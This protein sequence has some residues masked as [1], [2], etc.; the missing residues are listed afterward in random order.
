M[1]KMA[2]FGGL[3]PVYGGG[4]ATY[5]EGLPTFDG[6]IIALA[7]GVA[8]AALGSTLD[9]YGRDASFEGSESYLSFTLGGA[10]AINEMY[11]FCLGLRYITG[12][13]NIAGSIKN[14]TATAANGADIV[15]VSQAV[16]DNEITDIE[17][18]LQQKGSGIGII[19]GFDVKPN[20]QFNIGFKY[21]YYTEMKY[22]NETDKAIAPTPIAPALAAYKDGEESK[23]TIPMMF[24]IGASYMPTELF[25]AELGIAYY[26]NSTVDWDNTPEGVTSTY[27]QS[28]YF[29][30]GYEIGISGEYAIVPDKF[31]ASLGYLYTFN[32]GKEEAQSDLDF[33]QPSNGLSL[34]GI[35]SAT[36]TLDITLGYMLI[37]YGEKENEAETQTYNNTTH[38]IGFG[39]S[40]YKE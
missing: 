2:F 15:A 29:D 5:D 37:K 14:I 38:V 25:K 22:K 11:S 7:S 3:A 30:D 39:V 4:A 10:Y 40:C 8:Q 28:D 23:V 1:E 33:H 32:G 12:T 36:P 17:L 34:G 24:S 31:K 13:K 18:D 26:M 9:T 21:E 35:Y 16:P 19:T 6:A 20:E 27:E